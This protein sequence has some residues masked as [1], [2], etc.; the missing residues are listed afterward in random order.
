MKA[1]SLTNNLKMITE[2]YKPPS[3]KVVKRKK[4][5]QKYNNNNRKKPIMNFKDLKI[6]LKIAL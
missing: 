5:K 2:E 6:D 1:P 3:R 4:K